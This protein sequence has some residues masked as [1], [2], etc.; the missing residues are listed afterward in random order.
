M[1]LNQGPERNEMESDHTNNRISDLRLWILLD[2]ARFVIGRLHE[3]ELAQ[4]GVTVPQ[5]SI[6]QAIMSHGNEVGLQELGEKRM[7]QHYSIFSLINRMIKSGLIEQVTNSRD[8]GY[9]II[10][11]EKGRE[12]SA[13]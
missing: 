9:R 6:L 13:Q 11:T 5:A 12:V 4:Y 10:I 1:H 8:K 3:M 7:R 2:Q